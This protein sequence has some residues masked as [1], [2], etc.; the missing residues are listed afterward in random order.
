MTGTLGTEPQ[1]TVFAESHD[2]AAA[3][4]YTALSPAGTLSGGH[5]AFRSA[6]TD[7]LLHRIRRTAFEMPIPIEST[8]GLQSPGHFELTLRPG[9]IVRQCDHAA[10]LRD[11]VKEIAAQEGMSATFMAA[12]TARGASAGHVSLLAARDARRQ[13]VRRP[14]RR[15]R[16]CPRSARPSW[17][18]SS[19]TPLSCSSCTRRT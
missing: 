16:D 6:R 1:F 7:G 14:L 18:V 19:S 4:G 15:L 12:P 8:D 17:P 5:L 11:S 3:A 13:R 10:V 2:D 9:D